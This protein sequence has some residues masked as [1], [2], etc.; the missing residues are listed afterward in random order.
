MKSSAAIWRF[1]RPVDP[2]AADDHEQGQGPDLWLA[3][4]TL[5]T[6][7]EW[8]YEFLDTDGT[9]LASGMITVI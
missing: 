1:V 6:P 4:G 8:K 7:G 3:V 5:G 9:V 2:A